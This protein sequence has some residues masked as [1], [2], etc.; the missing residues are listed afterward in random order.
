MAHPTRDLHTPHH[1]THTTHITHTLIHT[2]RVNSD[3][4]NIGRGDCG[5]GYPLH[6]TAMKTIRQEGSSCSVIVCVSSAHGRIRRWIFFASAFASASASASTS[7]YMRIPS[8]AYH[9]IETLISVCPATLTPCS[10]DTHPGAG[11][12]PLWSICG[13]GTGA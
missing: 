8:A 5:D 1:T 6:C 7:A 2:M 4:N 10:S 9:K 12:D 11:S 13:V 3:G